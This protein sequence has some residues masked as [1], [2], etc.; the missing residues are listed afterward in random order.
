MEPRKINNKSKVVRVLARFGAWAI[1]ARVYSGAEPSSMHTRAAGT[2]STRIM[3]GIH[4]GR[5][6]QT[7]RARRPQAGRRLT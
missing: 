2:T 3:N 1:P 4:K 5:Q 6:Q 7:R